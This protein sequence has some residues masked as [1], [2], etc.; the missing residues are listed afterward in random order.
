M[1]TNNKILIFDS[2]Y[3][4]SFGKDLFFQ[5]KK[6]SPA[7]EYVNI[8]NFKKRIFYGLKRNFRRF[9][10]KKI[11]KNE[12]LPHYAELNQKEFHDYAVNFS[13][14][15]LISI[16]RIHDFV[17]TKILQ[18]LKDNLGV[19]LVYYDT[20]SGIMLSSAQRLSCFV[21]KELQFFDLIFSF[22]KV[23]TEYFVHRG[24]NAYF[25]PY[26]VNAISMPEGQ[27]KTKDITFVGD[28]SIRR[29]IYLELISD[30]NLSVYGKRWNRWK[31]LLSP[32]LERKITCQDVW[33]N[34][35]NSILSQSKIILNINNPAWHLVDSGV[36]LRIFETLAAKQFLLTE[37]I[38]ELEDLFEV[39]KDLETFSSPDELREKLNYYLTH[40]KEREI[41]AEH[42]HQT[43]L[44]K[45]TMTAFAEKLINKI[46]EELGTH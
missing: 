34:E 4:I 44:Q 8:T 30:F 21:K 18:E 45:H 13:P 37:Y 46:T 22:S 9:F 25:L 2:L 43:F 33:G 42:G 23:M 10:Y 1:N 31:N 11:L 40:D 27:Q 3:P 15:I 38:P 20:D 28:R 39:G 29:A 17:E 6:L 7:V 19:Y 16:G 12:G 26:G 41:I 36:N 35:L 5:M 32:E 24:L 14:S